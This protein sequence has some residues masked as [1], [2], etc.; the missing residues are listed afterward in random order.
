M[1]VR[2]HTFK[3]LKIFTLDYLKNSSFEKERKLFDN[4]FITMD[5]IFF[6]NLNV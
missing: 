3:L 2:L 5:A 1:A 4:Y 6:N